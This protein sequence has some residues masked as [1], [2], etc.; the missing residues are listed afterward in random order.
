MEAMADDIGALIR[1]LKIEKADVMGY[2]L[3]GGV[4]L[5]TAVRHPELVRKLVVVSAAFKRDGWYPEIVAGMAQVSAAAAEPMKQTPMYQLYARIAPKPA[6]WPVLL[7]KTGELLRKHYDW[8][9]DVAALKMPTML[10][11]GDADA[12]RTALASSVTPFLSAAK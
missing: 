6:D 2:S 4:A 5:Q 12:V 1:Y 3:G 11:F 7:T 10:V 8:S 9:K